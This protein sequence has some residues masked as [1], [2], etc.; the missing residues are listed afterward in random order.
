MHLLPIVLLV[1]CGLSPV[2]A[3]LLLYVAHK[4]GSAP[5]NQCGLRPAK[6]ETETGQEL[7]DV[8]HLKNE[9]ELTDATARRHEVEGI[10]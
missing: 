10:S 7:C 1:W 4:A 3:I 5:C 8:C 6:W 2:L 9:P